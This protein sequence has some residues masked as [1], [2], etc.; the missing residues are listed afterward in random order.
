MFKNRIDKK[1]DYGTIKPA[2]YSMANI[3]AQFA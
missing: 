3:T 2:P 1:L